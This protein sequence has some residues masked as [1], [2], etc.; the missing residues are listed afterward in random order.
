MGM[1]G[2]VLLVVARLPHCG[3]DVP[4]VDHLIDHMAHS[5]LG[6]IVCVVSLVHIKRQD[7]QYRSRYDLLYGHQ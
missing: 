3:R 2:Y 5:I 1:Y 4:S 7:C 6:K